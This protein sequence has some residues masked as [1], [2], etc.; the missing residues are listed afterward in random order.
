M[1][2]TSATS[3]PVTSPATSLA[4][5]LSN[6]ATVAPPAT[7]TLGQDDFLKLLATQFQEQDPMKPMDDTA[8][9]AQMAQFTSLE[10]TN[11]LV[12]QVTTL[13]SGQSLNTANGYLGRNVTVNDANGNPVTGLVT[14]VDTDP[15][16]GVSL[17]IGG[18]SYALSAVRRIEASGTAIPTTTTPSP[19]TTSTTP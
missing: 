12:G 1:T 4:N 16:N 3:T 14:E 2:V 8:F 9:I 7:K 5:V 18:Q 6:S 15:T 17:T 19:T 13:N 10:Q 11:N